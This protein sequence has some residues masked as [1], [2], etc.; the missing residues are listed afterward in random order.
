MLG[1]SWANTLNADTGILLTRESN[2]IDQ[3]L[4]WEKKQLSGNIN[5]HAG[6]KGS[7]QKPVPAIKSC[8]S[9][10][11]FTVV[12]NLNAERLVS[13]QAELNHFDCFLSLLCQIQMLYIL[14]TVC[15]TTAPSSVTVLKSTLSTWMEKIEKQ[16]S[17][18]Q[19]QCLRYEEIAK[20]YKYWKFS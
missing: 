8:H 18:C 19:I 15:C 1:S 20:I 7:L 5:T 3:T 6:L 10:L 13:S 11:L 2:S 9:S 14:D 12:W 4:E 16:L 17:Y